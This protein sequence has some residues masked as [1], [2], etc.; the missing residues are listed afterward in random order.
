MKE[1]HQSQREKA[2]PLENRLSASAG[3]RVSVQEGYR[4]EAVV[5]TMVRAKAERVPYTPETP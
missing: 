4:V 1:A 2:G 3:H 5:L